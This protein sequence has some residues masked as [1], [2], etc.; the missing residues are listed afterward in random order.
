M[1]SYEMLFAH[2]WLLRDFFI[3]KVIF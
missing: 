3:Y 2:F 1:I